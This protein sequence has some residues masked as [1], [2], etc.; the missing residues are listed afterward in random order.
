MKRLV[1][2]VVMLMIMDRTCCQAQEA[3]VLA[4][5]MGRTK[6]SMVLLARNLE[7]QGYR[8]VNW[9]YSSTGL[10]VP[11]L[12]HDLCAVVTEL[13][14]DMDISAINFV[15]HS[16]GGIIIRYLLASKNIAKAKRVVMLAP[17]NQGSRVADRYGSLLKYLMPPVTD[18]TTDPAGTVHSIPPLP[19]SIEVGIIVGSKDGKV[20]IP[21]SKLPEQR[22]HLVVDAGH[23]F[24]MN[25]KQ[26]Q[27]QIVRFLRNGYFNHTERKKP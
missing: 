8:V 4:H 20:S 5:G 12:S 6:L 25:K 26:V 2:M 21:E 24:L 14:R 13:S 22:D 18:L 3:V 10:Q 9:N 15:G 7:H 17:P 23:T 11:E 19:A 1:I 27:N 16:L